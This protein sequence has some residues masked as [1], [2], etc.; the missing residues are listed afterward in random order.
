MS[1]NA[2]GT[3][4]SSGMRVLLR[5]SGGFLKICVNIVIYALVI[6]LIYKAAIYSYDFTYRV[7][8]S[9]TV[10][11]DEASGRE[12]KIQILK[13][14]TSMNIAAKLETNKVIVDKYSFFV[15]LKLRGDEVMPGTYMLK[16]WSTYDD[17]I[18]EITDATKS[19]EAEE[20]VEDVE[21]S[22]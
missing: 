18:R 11:P 22:P 6:F 5:M 2:R 20:S 16:S 8:G 7:M 21:G 14:E 4:R 3:G 13:G 15:K 12:V 1:S 17:I 10:D 9:E 19:L